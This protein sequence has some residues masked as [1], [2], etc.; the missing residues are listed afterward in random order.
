M[1]IKK[2]TLVAIYVRKSRL[3]NDDSLEIARQV[4]LLTD[5]AKINNMDYEIFSEEWSGED[6]DRPELKRMFVNLK[7]NVYDG[8]LVTDQDRLTRNKKDFETFVEF[9]KS[10]GL[11][12]YTLDKIY[13]FINDDDVNESNTQTE[14]DNH[15][16][17]ITKRKLLRG[18]IHA[19][20]KGVYFG[21]APYGY[22]KDEYKHLLPH[23]KES[24]TVKDIFDMY[25]NRKLN[26][27]EICQILTIKGKK[28][29]AGKV[30][31]PRSTS[32]ILS[33]VAYIGVVSYKLQ[34]ES[35][36]TVEGAHPALVSMEVFQQAQSI[37]LEKRKV[38]QKSQRGI[39]TL[40]KLLECS[41]CQQTL[42]F[43]MKYSKREYKNT[44]DKSGRELY[45]LN[46]YA[47]KGQKAKLEHKLSGLP[48]CKN[49][50][51]RALRVQ[52]KV[53]KELKRYLI[54]LNKYTESIINRD[55]AFFEKIA[56]K[57]SKLTLQYDE[58]N[59]QKKNV[60]EGFRIGVY[61]AEE[62]TEEI[63]NIKKIQ[64]EIMDELKQIE[65][66]E[67]KLEVERCNKVKTNI[68][69]LLSMDTISNPGKANKILHEI[70]KKIYYWKETTDNGGEQPF[71]IKIVYKS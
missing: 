2:R 64:L 59:K 5:Y 29:R 46:C 67:S 1:A 41:C 57:Q 51:V 54:E 53:F 36:I 71:D 61:E 42:S 44:L 58:L 50:G 22:M 21:I 70:I 47:S 25:V 19:I 31:T 28:T 52:K 15:F 68:E 4:E 23:P 69:T 63:K 40:S 43:C 49:N 56:F 13:N 3:K 10:E 26:Q 9:A 24:Q 27:A 11:L 66:I 7:K 12:L 14:I 38:P 16:I 65:A 37:R 18:R 62:A 39:Y 34:E 48:R 45:I 32:L 20:K 35:A 55:E 30:F 17:E 60:Q 6:W 8:V 33:N